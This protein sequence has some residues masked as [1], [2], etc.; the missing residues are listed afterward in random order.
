MSAAAPGTFA[1]RRG[2]AAAF[3]R[4]ALLGCLA[5]IPQVLAT[6]PGDGF[7]MQAARQLMQE[8]PTEPLNADQ[9]KACR[10]DKRPLL[11]P[12]SKA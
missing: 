2:T 5:D 11:G 3:A 6:R 12:S 8:L 10:E 9:T 1:A 7:P 4:P